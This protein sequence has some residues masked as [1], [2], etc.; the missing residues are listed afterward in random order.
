[1]N[2][3]KKV[4]FDLKRFYR[5]QRKE[6]IQLKKFYNQLEEYNKLAPSNIKALKEEIFPCLNDASG[7]TLIDP[8][9]FFQ[10]TWAFECILNSKT[11]EHV[12][13]GSHHKFIAFLSKITKVTMVDIRPLAVKMDSINFVKGDILNLPFGNNSLNSVSS[14]CVIEHIGLGRYGDTLDPQG[15]I[16]AFKE[17][18]RVLTSGA[19]FYISVPVSDRNIVA[20]NGG[21]IFKNEELL[22]NLEDLYFI[23][24]KKYIVGQK[25]QDNFE[26]HNRFGSTI[27]LHLIKK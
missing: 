12:D 16:K 19:N 11:L 18:Y 2:T 22:S 17:I 15:S 14:I 24:D 20:F 1:M 27:L 10:D 5:E 25:L 9:Y 26:P 4:Y 3:I 8:V 6:R 7:E 21:R 23:K 13:I